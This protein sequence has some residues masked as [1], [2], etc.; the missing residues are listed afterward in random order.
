MQVATH[1]RHFTG[2][3][4][5]TD[6]KNYVLESSPLD[7]YRGTQNSKEAVRQVAGQFEAMFLNILMQSMRDTS[8]SGEPESSSLATFRGLF[9]QQTVQNLS[10]GGG[11]G[12]G[13]KL[14]QYI[15]EQNGLADR[16]IKKFPDEGRG[17]DVPAAENVP[18]KAVQ[19][20]G[21][22]EYMRLLALQKPSIAQALSK[23]SS[24]GIDT[25]RAPQAS[26]EQTGNFLQDMLVHAKPASEALG[27]SPHIIVAHA[28]LESG[29][30][31]RNIKNP[32]GSNSHNLFGIKATKNW[33]GATTDIVT[34]EYIDGV[35]QKRVETFRSY[36]SYEAAFADYARLIGTN[37]RYRD[38][39]NKGED[40]VGFARALARGGYATDPN[41]AAK[42]SGVAESRAFKVASR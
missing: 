21:S 9:D 18:V 11:I 22:P 27:V 32:D 26:R 37:P 35:R 33:T 30:G 36:P 6:P 40:A 41:Y 14:A 5:A 38:A 12:L 25:A 31:K 16:T 13:E 10:S 7:H 19:K 23:L 24:Q 1:P 17:L 2:S 8:F 29:W 3:T 34:T 4:P 42:L 20:A 15:A 39:L 28:A